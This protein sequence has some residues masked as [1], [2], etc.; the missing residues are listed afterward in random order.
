MNTTTLVT[1]SALLVVVERRLRDGVA[2]LAFALSPGRRAMLVIALGVVAGI[3]SA[4]IAGTSL[5]D[6]ALA[7]VL[8]AL[9]PTALAAGGSAAA[10]ATDTVAK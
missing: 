5:V 10:S 3:V 4:K 1:L 8:A 9:A 2:P 7:G 6:A